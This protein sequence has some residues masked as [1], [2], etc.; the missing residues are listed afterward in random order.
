MRN[1]RQFK[2]I[3]SSLLF[4]MM[5]FGGVQTVRAAGSGFTVTANL[6]SNQYNQAVSYFDV[7]MAP[8]AKQTFTVT[9]KNLE[10]QSKTI[11]AEANTGYTTDDGQESMNRHELGVLSTAPYQFN[12]IFGDVQKITLK[13]N[14]TKQVTFTAQMPAKAYSG[15]LEG[16]FYFEDLAAGQAQATNQAGFSIK[17]K[18]AMGIGVIL[19]ESATVHAQPKLQLQKIKLSQNNQSNP[20]IL[21]QLMNDQP[22]TI[23]QLTIDAIVTEKGQPNKVLFRQKQ[24][25]RSMA[26]NSHFNYQIPVGDQWLNP[27]QYRVHLVASN[28][29]YR[30]TFNQNFTISLKQATQINRHNQRFNWF[31]WLLLA[32]VIVLLVLGLTYY[33]GTRKRVKKER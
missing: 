9:V 23:G 22:A 26:A 10:N 16:A 6:P 4:F 7:L 13:P 14:E 11:K 1:Q 24:T 5:L 28:S 31:W 2:L 27:G 3:L 33:L 19:R 12:Q 21:A 15:I 20:A 17:N 29:Q 30:W 8:G 32:I 18:F 25:N